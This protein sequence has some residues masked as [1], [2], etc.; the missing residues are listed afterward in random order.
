MTITQLIE[1]LQQAE[2]E[3]NGDL[4]VQFAYNYGDHWH[5][6]VARAIETVEPRM[7]VHSYYH[8]MDKVVDDGEDDETELPKGARLVLILE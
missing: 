7:V 1:K 8:D 6:K 2:R 4:D 3:G 5:T